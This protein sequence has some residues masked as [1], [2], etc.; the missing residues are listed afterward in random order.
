MN[1]RNCAVTTL[2]MAIGFWA[3]GAKGQTAT[4]AS[5]GTARPATTGGAG[6]VKPAAGGG[7]AAA[8]PTTIPAV[9][10]S[11]TIAHD[12]YGDPQKNVAG[13]VTFVKGNVANLINDT[14]PAL[15]GRSRDNL[16]AATM[17]EG[18]P[19]SPAFLFEYGRALNNEFVTKL[20]PNASM[21]QRLNIA[22]VVAKVVPVLQ[23]VTLQQTTIQLINDPAEPVM[24]WGL[25][26]AQPQV[27]L[28]IGMK[29]P[30]AANQVPPLVAA[31]APAALK[32][33]SGPVFAEA[34]EALSATDSSVFA[35]L[36]KLWGYRLSQYQGPNVPEDPDVD[37]RPVYI[38]T[39]ASMWKS[40]INDKKS[41]G[42]VMQM[43][44]DQIAVAA[45]WADVS[46][47]DKR[48]HLVKLVVQ[49][50]GAIVVVGT[51]TQN[52]ALVGA[53]S[54]LSAVKVETLADTEKMWPRVQPIV[55]AIQTAYPEVQ[56]PPTVGNAE[57]AAAGPVVGPAGTS[58]TNGVAG[59]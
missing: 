2:L 58:G 24:L 22:I 40:V 45:Q 35:E 33:P 31:I 13:I 7:A 53:A 9:P 54:G 34:Y 18:Q 27:P 15:Q 57:G 1:R 10:V 26:A 47:G 48:D 39:T 5:G 12:I 38:L 28:V 14:D 50:A 36:R 30:G 21:R 32:H 55:T 23:N 3:A 52:Q 8:R 6:A 44:S 29:A 49:C 42:R 17:T 51:N 19:A 16:A 41:Q 59:K 25:K 37:G 4:P 43:V 20:G 56:P 11:A 46:K